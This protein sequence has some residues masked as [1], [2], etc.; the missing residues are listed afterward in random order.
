MT[1]WNPYFKSRKNYEELRQ[2]GQQR[3]KEYKTMRNIYRRLEKALD[4]VT[5]QVKSLKPRP[6]SSGYKRGN[7][8]TTE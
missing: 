6:S 7:R 3:A 1:R 5:K 4:I 8:Y 2:Q